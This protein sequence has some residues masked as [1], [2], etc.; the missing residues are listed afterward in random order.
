M[1]PGLPPGTYALDVELKG[2]TPYHA[3]DIRIGAG[4][5]IERTVILKLAGVA[6]SVVVEGSGSRIE[7]RGSGLRLAAYQ[8]GDRRSPRSPVYGTSIHDAWLLGRHRNSRP[9][10]IRRPISNPCFSKAITA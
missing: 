2:F 10:V 9:T 3:E 1:F 5:T 7:A 6:E 8:F 4:A